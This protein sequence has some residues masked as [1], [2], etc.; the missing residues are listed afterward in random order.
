MKEMNVLIYV[1]TNVME[2]ENK[3]ERVWNFLYSGEQLFFCLVYM[4]DI[5]PFNLNQMFD[6]DFC[7]YLI[8]NTREIT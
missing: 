3:I 8:D 6:I 5:L 4:I 7:G 1:N 2:G